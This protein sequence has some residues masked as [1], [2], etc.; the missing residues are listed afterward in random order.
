MVTLSSLTTAADSHQIHLIT[1]NKT[2]TESVFETNS[3]S[4]QIVTEIQVI[5]DMDATDT[6]TATVRTTGESGDVVDV[7]NGANGVTQFAGCLLA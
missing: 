1:S 2:Y 6:A 5:A 3:N 4:G 7:Q